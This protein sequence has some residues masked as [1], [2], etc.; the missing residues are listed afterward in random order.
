[1]DGA[2]GRKEKGHLNQSLSARRDNPEPQEIPGVHSPSVPPAASD[3]ARWSAPGQSVGGRDVVPF[4]HTGELVLLEL[5]Y[6]L[7]ARGAEA[8]GNI[9]L[10][11][12]LSL[13][14]VALDFALRE[15]ARRAV[16]GIANA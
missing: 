5:L 4:L 14:R 7:A 8:E 12:A 16:E 2:Q 11:V 1:M 13:D 9:P 10:S 15:R 3:E 6:R